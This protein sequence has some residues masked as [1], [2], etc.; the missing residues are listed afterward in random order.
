[1][2]CI[3]F[4]V[5]DTLREAGLDCQ[6]DEFLKRAG[7]RRLRSEMGQLAREYVELDDEAGVVSRAATFTEANDT[8][9]DLQ[10]TDS[11]AEQ[12]R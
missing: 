2:F 8:F 3:F 6:V 9:G 1:M 7:T 11:D 4:R 10:G 12:E 5:R